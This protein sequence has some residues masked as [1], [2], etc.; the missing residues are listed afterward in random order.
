MGETVIA[1]SRRVEDY[2]VVE[3]V[4]AASGF[5]ITR[6]IEGGQRSYKGHPKARPVGG[7]DY[8]ANQWAKQHGIECHT[9]YALWDVYGKR[10]GPI[11]NR[12]MA[13]MGEQLIAILDEESTGTLDMIK[14][15]R[16]AG[17]PPERIYI[18]RLNDGDSHERA[19][20]KAT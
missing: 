7:V 20:E 3:R 12:R 17:Y 14:A 15:A 18:Y 11:R 19:K 2:D 9:E 8:H 16:E 4:I 5:V 6:V 1:G 10:A 13:L